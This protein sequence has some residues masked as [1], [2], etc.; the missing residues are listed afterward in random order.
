MLSP[1]RASRAGRTVREPITAT[2]T[3]SIIAMPNEAKPLS[4]VRNIPAIATITVRPEISTERP[5]VAAAAS[6][7][8]CS[9]RPPARSSRQ[10]LT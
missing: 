6:R 8:A 10:R 7:D 1:S 4:P 2:A 5:E 3:T 9:L